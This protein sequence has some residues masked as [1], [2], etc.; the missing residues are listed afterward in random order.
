MLRHVQ[1]LTIRAHRN[2]LSDS[3]GGRG[4]HVL[5]LKCHDVHLA[6]ELLNPRE[7]FV[8]RGE[9]DVPNRSGGRV[10][11]RRLDD[12]L[13]TE[14]ARGDGKHPSQLAASQYTNGGAGQNGR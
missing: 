6:R 5:K 9:F 14:F 7:I 4:R 13:V 12:Y 1:N 2:N 10:V 3:P 8:G 11:V